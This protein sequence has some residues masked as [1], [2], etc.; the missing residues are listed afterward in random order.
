MGNPMPRPPAPAPDSTLP[1]SA[2]I[3]EVADWLMERALTE[4]TV[5]EIVEGC[6][7]RLHAAGIPLMRAHVAFRTL[8]PLYD[9][10]GLSWAP[11][12]GLTERLFQREHASEQVW[13]ESPPQHLIRTR[14]PFLR[15]RLTGPEALLDFP[16]LRE[17][18]DEGGTDYLIYLVAF[19]QAQA[20][21]FWGSW[22]TD[23]DGG[24]SESDI[25]ALRRIQQRFGVAL[26]V[27]I[28]DQI[29]HNVVATYLGPDAGERVLMGQIK[30]GDGETIHAA[31]WMSDLRDSTVLAG[32]LSPE[33]YLALLNSYFEC[34]AG[35]VLAN[36]GEVLLLIGDAVLAIFPVRAGEEAACD[37]ALQAARD[38][39]ARLAAL[40]ETRKAVG[41]GPIAFGVGL[42]L[43][44]LMFGNIGVPERLQ[45]TVTGPAAN[46]VA[47]L[48]ALTKTLDRPVLDSAAF[49]ERLPRAWKSLGMHELR[50]VEGAREI[51][52]P[53]L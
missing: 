38:A 1:D 36:G 35:A 25:R 14:T 2:L 4:S 40:N 37:A 12:G 6:F 49:A 48:E 31:I 41:D 27:T 5:E 21:G 7:L 20:S 50:G 26:K 46:E 23:R 13:Q 19:D 8:H 39:R 44:A 3:D 29:A 16:V 28:K 47:R 33:S 45:F 24:F 9:A 11:G 52:A 17:F 42:H 10:V 30:R 53:A 18:R 15:R 32:S 22:L 43:G 51:F 34:T